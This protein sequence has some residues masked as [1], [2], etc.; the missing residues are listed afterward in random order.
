V[1]RLV[2]LSRWVWWLVAVTGL[3]FGAWVS[4]A[5]GDGAV[6]GREQPDSGI[7]LN[8]R[9]GFDGYYKEGMWLP[10]RIRV[11]NNG[12]DTRGQLRIENPGGFAGPSVSFTRDVDLPTQSRREIF[13]YIAP[14]GFANN[15]KVSLVG[16]DGK[17]LTSTTARAVQVSASDLLYGV[18]AGSASAFSP[19]INITP[20]NGT[21]S[22]AVLELADLPPA[23]AAWQGLDVLVISD[24]DTGA[25][26]L[27]Q[28]TALAAWVSNGGRLIVAGGPS[29]QKTAAGLGHLLPITPSGSQTLTQLNELEAFVGGPAL[30]GQAIVA[31]GAL[32]PEAAVLVHVQGTPFA[33][34]RRIG[35]GQVAF[36]AADPALAPLRGWDGTLNLFRKALSAPVDRPGWAFGITNWSSA[37]EAVDSLPGLQLPNPLL[38][39]GFLGLYL[40]IIGPVNY[41]V[42]RFVKR[43]EL[44]WVTIPG[45]VA[46]FSISAYVIGSF[47]SG[48]QPILHQLSIVQAWPDSDQARVDQVVGLFS[49]RRT[50]Y[51]VDFAPGFLVRP[52]QSYSGPNPASGDIRI[53]QGDRSRLYNVRTD[54][55]SLERFIAVGRAPAPRFDAQ[56]QTELSGGSFPSITLK[57]AIIN[58]SE[59]T[60]DEAILLV[61]GSVERLGRFAPGETRSISLSLANARASNLPQ[62]V[63]VP[64][65]TG[66][67]GAP[68]S[69]P[70]YSSQYDSTVDDILGTSAYYTDKDIYRKYL[71]LSA[72]INTYSGG[73]RGGGVYLVGWSAS[74]PVSAEVVDAAYATSDQT[75]YFIA[76]RSSVNFAGSLIT[77]SPGFM[78]WTPLELT[79]NSG[80][81]GPYDISIYA[82]ESY[83]LRFQPF[84]PLAFRAVKDLTLHLYGTSY[85]PNSKRT[86]ELELWDFAENAWQ[87][88]GPV[89]YGDTTLAQPARF[90]GPGGEIQVRATNTTTSDTINIT[91][92]DFTLTVER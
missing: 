28:R 33:I 73:G 51:T 29:W 63:I 57:G 46:V 50:T 82:N 87:A 30:E 1:K 13:L 67:T 41:L 60:L 25:L 9:L 74:A 62:N 17:E 15:L 79:R 32:A 65:G 45:I 26:S 44:A 31:T 36:L 14:D 38:I 72:A 83:S 69:V 66:G 71:L 49:P 90:V 86:P 68:P 24:V 89:S 7:T 42:L 76:L 5:Q 55:A 78:T 84:Q 47:L 77:V 16:L 59:V 3:L 37:S 58:Q 75:V 6:A 64:F 22:L 4:R 54:I 40:I 2:T 39:C 53:E 91:T 52:L 35:F 92:L 85:G 48:S 10:V 18:L 8:A 21:A 80:A 81:A 34:A 70:Y 19:L 43:R 12:S 61:P 56:L 11:E 20:F 27:E 88:L 23:H